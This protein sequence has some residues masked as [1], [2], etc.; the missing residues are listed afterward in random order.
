MFQNKECILSTLPC[1]EWDIAFGD[2]ISCHYNGMGF[3]NV[4]P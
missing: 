3:Y 4:W 2:F 1:K